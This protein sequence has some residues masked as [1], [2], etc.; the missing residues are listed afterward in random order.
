MNKV[1]VI[2]LGSIATRHR[3]NLKLLYPNVVLYAVSSSGRVPSDRPSD[4]D[5]FISIDELIKL[6]PDMVIVA[7]PATFHARHAI[8]LLKAGIPTLIEKPVTADTND[9]AFLQQV[10]TSISTPFAVA[11]CLRYLPSCQIMKGLLEKKLVGETHNAFIQI[12]QYLPD[13]RPLKNYKNSVSANKHLGGGALLELSH[14]LDYLQWFFGDLNVEHAILR[15]SKELGLDVEDMADAVLTT[16]QGMVCN[17]H[18]DFL[19][20]SVQRTCSVVGSQG[21]LDWDL[22]ENRITLY[23]SEG[24]EILYSEPEWDK[25]QMYLAM[26]QDFVAMIDNKSHACIDL[27]TAEKIVQLIETIKAKANWSK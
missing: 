23:N 25:N 12:G 27:K 13:W 11:Y 24:F 21:R 22:I 2:G 3:R 19:Q 5:E 15:S 16:D 20:R 8:P 14:E 1:A 18:L 17:V 10:M 9:S 6:H 26:V 4:S 7:S